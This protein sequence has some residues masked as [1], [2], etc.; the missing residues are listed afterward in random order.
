M[1][2]ILF[3]NSQCKKENYFYQQF[4]L[5]FFFEKL[6]SPLLMRYHLGSQDCI[7]FGVVSPIFYQWNGPQH[8]MRIEISRQQFHGVVN[9][10]IDKKGAHSTNGWGICNPSYIRMYASRTFFGKCIAFCLFSALTKRL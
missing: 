9:H 8:P 4:P 5:P 3:F 10:F 2:S 6:A 1:Y 7:T